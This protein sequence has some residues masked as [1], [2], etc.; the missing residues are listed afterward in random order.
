M[1]HLYYSTAP[2]CSGW[3]WLPL[4][5]KLGWFLQPRL[6]LLE[7][8]LVLIKHTDCGFCGHISYACSSSHPTHPIV[9][10]WFT[11]FIQLPLPAF[12]WFNVIVC[13][14][15]VMA[16]II[17]DFYMH[18]F[19]KAIIRAIAY[20][21]LKPGPNVAY[22][23][24]VLWLKISNVSSSLLILGRGEVFLQELLDH[25]SPSGNLTWL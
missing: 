5:E 16:A 11:A 24:P 15:F 14:R 17:E 2:C 9:A 19:W 22:S 20:K 13:S 23:L 10:T 18:I 1:S 3:L 12:T 25:L 21:P 4:Q 6:Y 8:R 7:Y